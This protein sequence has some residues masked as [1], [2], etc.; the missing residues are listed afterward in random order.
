VNLI[1]FEYALY[2]NLL[3]VQI[4]LV[5]TINVNLF[6]YKQ[7]YC[8]C[9]TAISSV[10]AAN[11]SVLDKNIQ[12]VESPLI[13]TQ[14]RILDKS[15]DALTRAR[16]AL[17]A[18]TPFSSSL[19]ILHNNLQI[20]VNFLT[21]LGTVNDYGKSAWTNVSS[22]SDLLSYTGYVRYKYWDYVNIYVAA[23]RNWTLSVAYQVNLNTS[24]AIYARTITSSQLQST[25]STIAAM[26][27]MNKDF[28]TYVVDL[29]L[30]VSKMFLY[31]VD[32]QFLGNT[33][34][35]CEGDTTTTAV[36][37]TTTTTRLIV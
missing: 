15:R 14:S 16:S 12:F 23:A 17:T 30:S 8:K 31:L 29:A 19:P 4:A 2:I 24:V 7:K 34:C 3:A 5:N 9:P 28:A 13:A 11:A 35:A 26:I 6:F 20:A 27:E 22:C 37:T 1:V 36:A 18:V 10:V 25:Q 33:F 32:I 21:D